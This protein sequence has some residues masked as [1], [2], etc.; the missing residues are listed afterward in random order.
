VFA[1]QTALF[2]ATLRNARAAARDALRLAFAHGAEALTFVDAKALDT[3]QVPCPTRTRGILRPGRLTVATR[4]PL[5]LFRAWSLVEPEAAGLV[6][7]APIHG[8]PVPD[9]S[10]S[11][12]R[13]GAQGKDGDD[14]FAGLRTYRAGDPLHRVSWK[15]SARTE[16]LHTKELT[17]EAAAVRWLD[18]DQALAEDVE[19]RLGILA[20]WVLE[21][22]LDGG[23]WG[24]R[25][26]GA[27]VNPGTGTGHRDLCLSE[28]A[29][30]GCE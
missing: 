4:Y 13:G 1:G 24:L 12:E 26:P 23:S 6:Y 15:T 5:G 19:T 29:R 30:L 28:L 22:S 14:D 20:A 9:P 18:W 27:T 2:P 11:Q 17:A 16:D 25:I 3:I 7:P 21:A 8:I 10:T